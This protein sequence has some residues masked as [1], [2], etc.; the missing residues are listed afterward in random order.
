MNTAASQGRVCARIVAAV[1]GLWALAQ[2]VG[3]GCLITYHGSPYYLIA[4]V[5]MI[6]SAPAMAKCLSMSS[7]LWFRLSIVARA[8]VRSTAMR[9]GLP[10]IPLRFDAG[11]RRPA[12][13]RSCSSRS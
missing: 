12:V 3:G 1:I 2:G 8:E 9:E 4:A 11:Y 13:I 5:V 7:S 10:R 6:A